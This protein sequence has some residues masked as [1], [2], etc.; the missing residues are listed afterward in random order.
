MVY[1]RKSRNIFNTKIVGGAYNEIKMNE[2]ENDKDKNRNLSIIN[3]PTNKNKSNSDMEE[4][5]KTFVNFK[6]K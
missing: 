3:I 5:L 6:F 4:K 2:I 1:S